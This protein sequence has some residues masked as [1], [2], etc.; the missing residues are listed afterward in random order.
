MA[1]SFYRVLGEPFKSRWPNESL[2]L[3]LAQVWSVLEPCRCQ[4]AMDGQDLGWSVSAECS[5]NEV[6]MVG[7]P[8]NLFP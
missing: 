8:Y 5:Q 1:D 6:E 3:R 2:V 7:L 4:F